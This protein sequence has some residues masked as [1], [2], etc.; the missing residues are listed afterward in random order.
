M[1]A[2]FHLKA[3]KTNM[4]MQCAFIGFGK[5]TAAD[6]HYGLLQLMVILT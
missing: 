2:A 4:N 1:V 5:I 3:S 6:V